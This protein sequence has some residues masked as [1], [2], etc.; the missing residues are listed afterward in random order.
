MQPL[1]ANG[2]ANGNHD[3]VPGNLPVPANQQGGSKGISPT[4][5][6]EMASQQGWQQCVNVGTVKEPSKEEWQQS[7]YTKIDPI[8]FIPG[9]VG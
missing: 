1:K 3:P 7:I 8:T 9:M 5:I 2:H 6:G 4:G